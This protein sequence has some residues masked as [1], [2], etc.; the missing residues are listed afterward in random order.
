MCLQW[1]HVRGWLIDNDLACT[2]CPLGALA[3]SAPPCSSCVHHQV[4]EAG[5]EICA[6]THTTLP[7][8][9]S[10]CHHNAPPTAETHIPLDLLP[11]A[12]WVTSRWGDDPAALLAT[13]HSA[14]GVAFDDAER[15]A[16]ALADLA[17]PLLY[18]VPA[19]QWPSAVDVPVWEP[20]P[21]PPPHLDAAIAY[22][23]RLEAGE[24]GAAERQAL[25]ALCHEQPLD[26]VVEPWRTRLTE[27]LTG[28]DLPLYPEHLCTPSHSPEKG[29][30][31][32]P[33]SPQA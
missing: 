22:L 5:A 19:A 21:P 4:D 8:R 30:V 23:E 11:I 10:C 28:L 24:E 20:T 7:H 16:L 3:P 29:V 14:P 17:T 9:R 2:G 25:I 26:T 15:P 18:G 33:P 27:A 6:L 12:P 32:R 1:C 31:G 13:H